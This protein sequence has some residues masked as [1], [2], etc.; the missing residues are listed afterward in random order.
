M[1][2][3]KPGRIILSSIEIEADLDKR[4]RAAIKSD[5]SLRHV[6][7]PRAP[8]MRAAFAEK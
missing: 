7:R 3:S 8:W 1:S 6:K 5:A 4:M 2:T